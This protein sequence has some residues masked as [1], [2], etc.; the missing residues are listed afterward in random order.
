MYF[1]FQ[2]FFQAEIEEKAKL[3]YNPLRRKKTFRKLKN[4]YKRLEVLLDE[5]IFFTNLS[6]YR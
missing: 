3:I 2:F 1:K 4:L 5:V 6:L